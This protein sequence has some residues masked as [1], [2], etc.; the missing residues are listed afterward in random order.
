MLATQFPQPLML[1]SVLRCLLV[2]FPDPTEMLEKFSGLG[3]D[4]MWCAKAEV[5]EKLRADVKDKRTAS[6][7]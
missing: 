2:N 3:W 1:F 7:D 4:P 6:N 5:K